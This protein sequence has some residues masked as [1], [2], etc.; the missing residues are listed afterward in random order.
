MK[1]SLLPENAQLYDY[2]W[3]ALLVFLC[4]YELYLIQALGLRK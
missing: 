4:L 2:F 3:Y 1:E